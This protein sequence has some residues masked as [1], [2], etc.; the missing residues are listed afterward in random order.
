ML[1][2][3]AYS[4]VQWE[5]Q[6]W[7][8]L[9]LWRGDVLSCFCLCKT[10][11][12]MTDI[13]SLSN[14][15]GTDGIWRLSLKTRLEFLRFD[16]GSIIYWWILT[17]VWVIACR[18]WVCVAIYSSIL[19]SIAEVV[20]GISM[21]HLLSLHSWF[22]LG[23][24]IWFYDKDKLRR[25]WEQ[26]EEQDKIIDIRSIFS[27]CDCNHTVVE[28]RTIGVK[29]T[30]FICWCLYMLVDLWLLMFRLWSSDIL[31]PSWMTDR[32]KPDLNPKL[33]Y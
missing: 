22:L 25:G 10:W 11:A 9:V 31:Q 20:D 12:C 1:L 13:F 6:L 8:S 3:L 27:C 26:I 18:V 21:F 15:S 33:S 30:S 5:L 32:D 23:L 7:L 4:L 14:D 24:A 2:K 16:A 28:R 17:M 29:E 19:R